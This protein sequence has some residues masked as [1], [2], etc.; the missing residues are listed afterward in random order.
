MIAIFY[1]V[2]LDYLSMVAFVSWTCLLLPQLVS[3]TKSILLLELCGLAATHL[4]L[5][6]VFVY[7]DLD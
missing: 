5:R 4:Q 6:I 1:T 3:Q 2:S 7:N